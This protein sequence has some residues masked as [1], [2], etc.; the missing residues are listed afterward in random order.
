VIKKEQ[1][2]KTKQSNRAK[3]DSLRQGKSPHIKAGQS[4]SIA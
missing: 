3:P 4:K 1:A 2:S